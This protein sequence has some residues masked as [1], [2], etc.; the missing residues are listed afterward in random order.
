[1]G[2]QT[3]KL[4]SILIIMIIKDFYV[5]PVSMEVEISLEGILC[6]SERGGGIDQLNEK[7]EHDWSDMWNS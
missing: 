1:M 4:I 6:A 7:P 3:I 5:S 2:Y